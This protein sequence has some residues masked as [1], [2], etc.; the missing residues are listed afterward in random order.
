MAHIKSVNI[1][2]LIVTV[3]VVSGVNLKGYQ[4]QGKL[5]FKPPVTNIPKGS[6][7]KIEFHKTAKDKDSFMVIAAAYDSLVADQKIQDGDLPVKQYGIELPDKDLDQEDLEYYLTAILNM[8]WC[9]EKGSNHQ[10]RTGDYV[11]VEDAI[12]ALENCDDEAKVCRG[13]T[14]VLHKL[15]PK[16]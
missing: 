5:S 9:R 7:L 3:T 8:G 15:K 4:L 14:I 2:L 11:T 6:C 12:V 16:N 1:I 10:F 13:P